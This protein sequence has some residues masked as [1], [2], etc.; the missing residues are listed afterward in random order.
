M[1]EFSIDN[2]IATLILNDG[3]ANAFSHEMIQ[4]INTALD[5]AEK[6]KA[7]LV[8]SA[9]GKVLSAGFHLPTM[10][11]SPESRADLVTS[12][13][14]TLSRLLSYPLPVIVANPGHAMAMGAFLLLGADYR[15][16]TRGEYKIGFNE[17]EIGLPLPLTGVLFARYRLSPL[18]YYRCVN[19]AEIQNPDGALNAGFVDELVEREDLLNRAVEKAEQLKS[20]NPTA[21]AVTRQRTLA[22]L[23][24]E[25]ESAAAED[26]KL[27]RQTPIN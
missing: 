4:E 19:L 16:G 5:T 25:L 14:S 23:L 6:E 12:G 2:G 11:E 24:N 3:K 27:I 10:M 15:I 17:V 7:I 22:P 9:T 26:D 20:L 1:I 18:A 13:F 21:F 8:I